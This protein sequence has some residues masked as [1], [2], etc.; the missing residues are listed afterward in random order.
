MTDNI[1]EGGITLM[2]AILLAIKLSPFPANLRRLTFIPFVLSW[3]VKLP[4]FLVI[5]Y[6]ILMVVSFIYYHL[7]GNHLTEVILKVDVGYFYQGGID[8]SFWSRLWGIWHF[9]NYKEEKSA[10]E[11]LSILMLR[12]LVYA[13]YAFFFL[14][15]FR[16]INIYFPNWMDILIQIKESFLKIISR[17]LPNI[18]N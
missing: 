2:Q 16:I 3:F 5:A 14:T 6:P 1:K 11:K 8:G 4:V 7:R 10:K 17:F 9:R 12:I 18:G 15:T 13:F